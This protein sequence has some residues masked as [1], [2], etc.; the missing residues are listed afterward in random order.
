MCCGHGTATSWTLSSDSQENGKACPSP[1][2]GRLRESPRMTVDRAE[3][4][5]R[6]SS[7]FVPE[8]CSTETTVMSL[9]RRASSVQHCTTNPASCSA[10]CNSPLWSALY[11]TSWVCPSE[12]SVHPLQILCSLCAFAFPPFSCR[13]SHVPSWTHAGQSR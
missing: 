3:E 13:P 8:D 11:I 1:P 12:S 2:R 4:V 9:A 10:V 7:P 6:S 5:F